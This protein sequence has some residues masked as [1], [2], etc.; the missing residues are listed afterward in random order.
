MTE[1]ARAV[2]D[3][4]PRGDHRP[5]GLLAL[6]G[7]GRPRPAHRASASPAASAGR[8]SSRRSRSR[9]CGPATASRPPT[10]SLPY[11]MMWVIALGGIIGTAAGLLAAPMLAK[12]TRVPGPAA[13]PVHHVACGDRRLR[14]R[15]RLLRGDGDARLRGRRPRAAAAALLARRRSRSASSSAR[16]SRRTST[17]P[18]TSIRVDLPRPP[19][20]SRTAWL[21]L[22][23]L[24]PRVE[25][26]PDPRRSGRSAE[27]SSSASRR[28]GWRCRE[29]RPSSSPRP[30]RCSP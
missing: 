5:R 4:D 19:P 21:A 24:H 29:R 10:R 23:A 17:S 3:G 27:S 16:R 6:Q 25:D 11:E 7:G 13:R 14:R 12:V 22:G 20:A 30:T 26:H 9:A 28:S 8:S 2:R 18:T 15:R 1:Q